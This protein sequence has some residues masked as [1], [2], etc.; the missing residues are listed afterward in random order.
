MP[1][2]KSYCVPCAKMLEALTVSQ[3][4]VLTLLASGVTRAEVAKM[5]GIKVQ[6]VKKIVA[7]ARR[8][9]LNLMPPGQRQNFRRVTPVKPTSV[10]VQSLSLCF[11]R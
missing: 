3:R 4:S 10:K 6:A 2:R 9:I 8:R 1:A 11:P 7:R 5:R